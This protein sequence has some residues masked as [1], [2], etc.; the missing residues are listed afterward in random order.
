[1]LGSVSD[2]RSLLIWDVR[3]KA[4]AGPSQASK[5]CHDGDV[6]SLSF[7]P[8][9]PFIVATCSTDATVKLWDLREIGKPL[10]TFKGHKNDVLQVQWAPF[11]QT[12][13]ASCGEDRRVYV[14][15]MSRIGTEQ[16][17]EDAEDGPPE[18]LF[19][20]GGHT[21]KISDFS[22]NEEEPWMIASV[23]EDNIL[24]VWQP[25]EGI[26]DPDGDGDAGDL[27]ALEDELPPAA[28]QA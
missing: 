27:D 12:V 2:D 4:G 22:W 6:M 9:D 25:A 3:C 16:L 21:N 26:Y 15:D 19:I 17:P 14:W 10:Y 28:G 20:H 24:Q 11:E 13:L 5:N 7:N 23:A 18:L 1:M 8:V